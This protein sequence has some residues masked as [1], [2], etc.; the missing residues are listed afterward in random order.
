MGLSIMLFM[1]STF[2]APCE[3]CKLNYLKFIQSMQG[4]TQAISILC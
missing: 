4:V 2:H 1:K 3:I